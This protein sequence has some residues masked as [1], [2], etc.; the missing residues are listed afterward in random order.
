MGWQDQ[1]TVRIS[2]P[3]VFLSSKA[4]AI[5]VALA[6]EPDAAQLPD[7]PLGHE[8]LA[9]VQ[10]AY[11]PLDTGAVATDRL[12]VGGPAR[13]P[14]EAMRLGHLLI[15]EFAALHRALTAHYIQNDQDEAYQQVAALAT[16]LRNLK[17]R[18]FDNE[19][20]LVY[21]LEQQLAF[22][23]GHAAEAGFART[24]MAKLWGVWEVRSI[25]GRTALGLREK[26]EFTPDNQ[27]R[28][29]EKQNGAHVLAEESEYGANRRQIL[30][31]DSG[32]VYDYEVVGN[33]LVLADGRHE[34]R[35]F[36]QRSRLK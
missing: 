5:F 18:K 33:Q 30:V 31:D 25:E 17:D 10:L 22:A 23:S 20:K 26:L 13:V 14:S 21:Q 16:K 34:N 19:K 29:F 12:D 28:R 24:G 2:I 8:S 15:D 35:V 36:L 27:F 6:R 7:A 3:T 9:R 4:G 32:V 1:R 11:V